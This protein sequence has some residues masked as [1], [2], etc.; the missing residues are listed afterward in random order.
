MRVLVLDESPLFRRQ[1]I[2]ALERHPDIEVIGEAA[3]ADTGLRRTAELIPDVAVLTMRLPPIGGRR[4]AVSLRE[5]APVVEVLIVVGPDDGPE[6]ARLARAGVTGFVPWEAATAR[7][8]A[9]VEALVRGRPVLTP[10]AA[11]AVLAEY[12]R[13]DRHAGSI[14]DDLPPPTLERPERQVLER[15]A[16]GASLIGASDALAVGAPTA[17]N[18]VR[19]ALVK[20]QHHARAEAVLHAMHVPSTDSG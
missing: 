1:L 4:A 10:Q 11:A 13:L 12:E 17:A 16:D 9:V 15:L 8:A 19:N 7:C 3:D 18:L 6:L 2:V 20:L 14:Q 5:V